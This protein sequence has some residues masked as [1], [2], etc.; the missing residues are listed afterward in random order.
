MEERPMVV[1]S[2]LRGGLAVLVGVLA[3]VSPAS[4][5]WT[6]NGDATGRLFTSAAAGGAK[7]DIVTSGFGV[8]G[9]VCLGADLPGRLFGGGAA[10]F[11]LAMTEPGFAGCGMGGQTAVAR[12]GASGW[13]GVSYDSSTQLA[14]GWIGLTACNFIKPNGGCGNSTTITGGLVISGTVDTA[15][16]NVTDRFETSVYPGQNLV[17]SWTGPGCMQGTSPALAKLTNTSGTALVYPVTGTFVPQ[18]TN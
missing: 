12:C 7:F 1:R 6:T 13:N 14:A 8:P 3:L 2:T 10:G 5:N 9:I 15:Y 4:A 18:I 16:A 11:D 17:A